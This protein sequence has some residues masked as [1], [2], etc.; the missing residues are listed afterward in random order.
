MSVWKRIQNIFAKHEP[1]HEE[2]SLLAIGP[3]DVIEVSL[4]TYQVTGKTRNLNRN[5]VMLTLQDGNRVRYFLIEERERTVY[6]LYDVIDGRLDSV[7]EIPSTIKLDDATYHLEE[8]FSGKVTATGSTAFQS[9]GEQHIWQFQSDD[10][11]LLR[12]EWQDGRI[13]LYEGESILPADVQII[14][15]T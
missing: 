6:Q 5:A 7:D 15:G 8:Q 3:G 14:R 9:S 2:E 12:I 1:P 4:E 11:R 13:M 10:R